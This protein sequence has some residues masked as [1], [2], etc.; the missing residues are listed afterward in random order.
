M[1]MLVAS[2][3]RT[4]GALAAASI[5]CGLAAAPASALVSSGALIQQSD[6][7]F[8]G[9]RLVVSVSVANITQQT[10]PGQSVRLLDGYC[11]TTRARRV[12]DRLRVP[13]INGGI[14]RYNFD[15][16][17]LLPG[18]WRGIVSWLRVSPSDQ[19]RGY[20]WEFVC[21]T[22]VVAANGQRVTASAAARFY[23]R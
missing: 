18:E 2:K 12:P 17:R 23:V 3:R 22:N 20:T 7:I 1:F 13:M 19:M 21:S 8:A 16:L 11:D 5:L 15:S 10:G 9:T 4:A 6:N 14:E